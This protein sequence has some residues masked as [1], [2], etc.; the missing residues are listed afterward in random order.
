MIRRPPRST[1][2][3]YT[4]LFRSQSSN[5]WA[6]I[7]KR[8]R[9]R[10]LRDQFPNVAPGDELDVVLSEHFAKGVAGEEVE[11]ALAPGCAPVRVIGSGAAHLCVVVSEMYHDLRHAGF[12]LA[13]LVTVKLGPIL[14][15][16]TRI[17]IQHAINVDVLVC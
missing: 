12:E 14:R 11:V 7:R 4:T 8:L 16:D 1:L 17:D 5:A 6:E 13:Q 9:R 2:F 10:S 3:P 15:R